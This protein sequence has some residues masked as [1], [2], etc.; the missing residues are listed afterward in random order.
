MAMSGMI[1]VDPAKL[2]S[3]ASSLNSTGNQIKNITQQ[4]LSIANGLT[5]EVYSGDAANQYRTK[6]KSNEADMN[7]IIAKITEHVTDLQEMADTYTRAETASAAKAGA[8]TNA[9]I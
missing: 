1:K 8:L 7:K 2:K 4:M 3:T 9:N 6:F 5:G